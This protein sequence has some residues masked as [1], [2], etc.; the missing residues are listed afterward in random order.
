MKVDSIKK[1]HGQGVAIKLAML[2]MKKKCRTILE[3]GYFFIHVYF[4]DNMT[5]TLSSQF[6]TYFNFQAISYLLI[7]ITR[8]NNFQ[9]L[10]LMFPCIQ[11]RDPFINSSIQFHQFN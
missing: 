11:N 10:H 9:E 4:C 8:K 1:L 7:I 2:L 5:G 6:S 3:M